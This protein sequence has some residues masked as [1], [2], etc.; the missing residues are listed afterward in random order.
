MDIKL[1]NLCVNDVAFLLFSLFKS[2]SI[3]DP[4]FDGKMADDQCKHCNI[5][6]AIKRKS[7]FIALVLIYHVMLYIEFEAT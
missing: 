7:C 2:D 5:Y 6:T 1:R 3:A 4:M